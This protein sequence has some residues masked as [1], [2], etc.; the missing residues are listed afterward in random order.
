MT[1]RLVAW[2]M[3]DS[4]VTLCHSSSSSQVRLD[5]PVSASSNSLFNGFPSHLPPFGLQF[6][7]TFG[8]LLLFIPVTFHSQFDLYLPSFM[9]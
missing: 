3:A 9:L 7:I 5:G 8:T 6:D 4:V 1:S 2:L